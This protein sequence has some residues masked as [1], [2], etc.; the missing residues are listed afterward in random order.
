[1]I[2]VLNDR[3]APERTAGVGA[4]GGSPLL[5]GGRGV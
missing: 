4:G 3:G 2:G 5:P 1:M